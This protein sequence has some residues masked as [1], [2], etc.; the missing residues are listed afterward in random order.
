MTNEP[1]TIEIVRVQEFE[2]EI[3][4]HEMAI[5]SPSGSGKWFV[6]FDDDRDELVLEDPEEGVLMIED[7]PIDGYVLTYKLFQEI[8]NAEQSTFRP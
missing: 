5:Y 7:V 1:E 2:V 4:E 3:P 6:R 8:K